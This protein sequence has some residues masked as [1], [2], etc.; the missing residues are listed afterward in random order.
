MIPLIFIIMITSAHAIETQQFEHE[1]YGFTID[2]PKDWVIDTDTLSLSPTSK[3]VLKATPSES[4]DT[5]LSVT[6]TDTKE[7]GT[8]FD[9]YTINGKTYHYNSAVIK[10]L[11]TYWIITAEVLQGDLTPEE[12]LSMVASFHIPQGTVIPPEI[13]EWIR[14]NATWWGQG[15]I[16]D[17]EYLDA[18]RFLI[19]QGILIL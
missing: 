17:Q 3:V 6:K 11:D 8:P 14:N 4:F 15:L 10:Y 16:S 19:N 13:P 18:I 12:I 9:T 1:K 7:S 2:L 5:F